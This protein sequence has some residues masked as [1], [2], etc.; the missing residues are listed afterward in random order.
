MN[1]TQAHLVRAAV[2][3]IVVGGLLAFTF[4]GALHSPQPNGLDV[5]VV[6]P[7]GLVDPVARQIEAT[8][9]SAFDITTYGDEA[10][11]R[12]AILERDIDAAFI[13]GE[14]DS[15]LLVAGA[16]G[17]I[18]KSSL[19]ELFR[20]V[21]EKAGGELAVEDVR[22]LPEGDR[23]GL[24][25]FLFTVS[26]LVPSLILGAAIP[27]AGRG[28]GALHMLATTLLGGLVIGLSNSAIVDFGLDALTGHYWGVAG[29]ATL[30]SWAVAL[31]MIAMHR[32]LGKAGTGVMLLLFL[33]I[34]MPATGA[35]VG[36]DF[37]PDL[38]QIFTLAFPPGEAIPAFRNV[39]YFDAADTR[40][41]VLLLS[42]W[43][44]AG[45]AL[46]AAARQAPDLEGNTTPTPQPTT[47]DGALR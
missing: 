18:A 37:I 21:A 16:G 38:F 35:G 14:T 13:P 33:V 12:Q 7:P 19:S 32:L 5:A 26:I 17:A 8:D 1:H 9:P 46:L 28:A 47:V 30:T 15:R 41:N 45:A 20:E 3:A 34:G 24:S 43:A 39:V 11:A 31:P 2:M 44:A 27:L 22:P 29:I 42:S 40:L 6:G 10:E 25:P 23:A 4:V 36:P